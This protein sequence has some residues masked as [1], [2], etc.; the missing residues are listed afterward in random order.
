MQYH[1]FPQKKGFS[2]R[3]VRVEP[4]EPD[5][6]EQNLLNAAKIAGPT[7]GILELKQTEFRNG[8]RQMIKEY[9]DPCENPLDPSV[10]W[11]KVKP[12]QFDDGFSK[13]FT[14]KDKQVLEALFRDFHEVL[15]SELDAI[16]GKALPVSAG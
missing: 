2:G 3:A 1:L 4:L 11:H 16:V 15:N 9:S 13:L 7:A 6:H 14:A 5:E 8:A 10:K 12:G